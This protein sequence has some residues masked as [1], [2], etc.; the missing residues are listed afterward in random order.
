M[1]ITKESFLTDVQSHRIGIIR[2]D[3]VNRHIRFKKPDALD[4]YFDLITWNGHL[5]YTGDMGTYVF[6]RSKD[7]FSFFRSV[8]SLEDDE[9]TRIVIN[10]EYWSEKC[11]AKDSNG[12]IEKFS[13]E[14]FEAA[15]N[16]YF[17]DWI[18]DSSLDATKEDIKKLSDAIY[19]EVINAEDSP[20]GYLK[21]KAASDFN[22]LVNDEVG[23]FYF[24]DFLDQNFDEY[25]YRFIWCC[26]AIVWGIMQ[27]DKLKN[28]V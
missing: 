4:M 14:L 22:H 6:S 15:V 11:I 2:D 13:D 27:Y 10:P 16:E 26:Y 17:S 18:A 8:S 9:S 21:L 28:G 7:M 20:Y 19:S 1:K 12:E 23:E 25:T 3:G 24:E 5:C